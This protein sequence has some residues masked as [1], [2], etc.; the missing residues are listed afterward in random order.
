MEKPLFSPLSASQEP[1]LQ[2]FWSVPGARGELSPGLQD[3]PAFGFEESKPGRD[4]LRS[5]EAP[6]HPHVPSSSMAHAGSEPQRGSGAGG[7]RG[8]E[9]GLEV[10]RCQRRCRVLQDS[11]RPRC[12]I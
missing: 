8:K 9:S 12:G 6:G 4:D 2:P 1:N 10:G 7:Q 11:P 5:V 3:G